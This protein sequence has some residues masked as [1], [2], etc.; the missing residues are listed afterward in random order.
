MQHVITVNWS[1]EQ[2]QFYSCTALPWRLY[3]TWW[4]MNYTLFLL[5]IIIS[6]YVDVG[7]CWLTIERHCSH[8]CSL[9][10]A[11]ICVNVLSSFTHTHTHIKSYTSV[12]T[13]SSTNIIGMLLSWSHKWWEMTS[14]V[15]YTRDH[16]YSWILFLFF[17]FF[18][19][20][21]FVILATYLWLISISMY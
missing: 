21:A 9:K 3:V 16:N 4:C 10:W 17:L 7:C 8:E 20:F 1:T 12:Y 14:I 2:S 11:Q 5:F 15:K 13:L 18:L 6:D 19:T